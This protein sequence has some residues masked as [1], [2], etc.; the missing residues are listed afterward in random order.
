MGRYALGSSVEEYLSQTNPSYR[1]HKTTTKRRVS[2][3]AEH[4][5]FIQ[6]AGKPQYLG[7]A[8]LA[9]PDVVP[10]Y[11]GGAIG[12]RVGSKAPISVITH[13][14]K[15]KVLRSMGLR[16]VGAVVG[17]S[18]AVVALNVAGVALLG[19]AGYRAIRKN[20]K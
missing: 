13:G 9:L 1:T 2:K 12:Q 18:T 5:L 10:L 15:A 7:S 3:T 17:G 11:A 8:L 14:T 4:I 16:T 20:R 6:K 19:Y